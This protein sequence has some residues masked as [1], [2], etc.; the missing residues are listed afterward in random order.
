ML[1]YFYA[2]STFKFECKQNVLGIK[3]NSKYLM[4][5]CVFRKKLNEIEV[6]YI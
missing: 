3:M 4:F 5:F 1:F 6:L 2:E